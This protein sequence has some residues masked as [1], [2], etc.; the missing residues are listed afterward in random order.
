[1]FP[2]KIYQIHKESSSRLKVI[3]SSEVE[4]HWIDGA[5]DYQQLREAGYDGNIAKMRLEIINHAK[6]L[7]NFLKL[8]ALD[9]RKESKLS[10]KFKKYQRE[11]AKRKNKSSS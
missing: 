5:A 6:N 7:I 3:F 4:E 8:E 10:I 11:K 9:I 2:A 1:M